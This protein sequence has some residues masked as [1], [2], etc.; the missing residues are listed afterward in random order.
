MIDLKNM[1]PKKWDL[2][3]FDPKNMYLKKWDLYLKMQLIAK[4]FHGQTLTKFSFLTKPV[5]Q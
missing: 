5:P 1:Y 4:N 2:Y 3:P